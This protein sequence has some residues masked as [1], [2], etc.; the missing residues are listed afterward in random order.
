VV[1][2]L[3]ADLVVAIH[4]AYV[5]YVVFGELLIVIGIPLGWR[6]IRNM[7]FRV[8]HLAMIMFVALEA[9]IQFECP[10]TTWEYQ[11]LAASGDGSEHRS[12]VGRLMHNLMFFDCSD[13]SWVWPWIYSS[14]AGIICLTF[15]LAP[16]RL[17]G[18]A[19]WAK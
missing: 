18:K 5:C 11:L 9:L 10:L 7:W 6:W 17:P 14:V 12:F 19:R 16:P 8:S 2:H 1:Y 3:L 4:L 15:V 13:E